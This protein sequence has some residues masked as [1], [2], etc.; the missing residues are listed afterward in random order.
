VLL[1]RTV[2]RVEL[3]L[4]VGCGC[5]A[6]PK[7]GI[8]LA[9]CPRRHMD[10]S[11]PQVF[12]VLSSVLALACG[13]PPT[14]HSPCGEG[15]DESPVTG[16]LAIRYSGWAGDLDPIPFPVHVHDAASVGATFQGCGYAGDDWWW[17]TT[18]FQFEE[19]SAFPQTYD[20]TAVGLPRADAFIER[21]TD[22][23]P[24]NCRREWFYPQ[25][26]SLALTGT[27]HEY[28]LGNQRV[29]TS[30]LVQL[31]PRSTSGDSLSVVADLTWADPS[32]SP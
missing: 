32:A 6:A 3:N 17:I 11:R 20:M 19:G 4:R 12:V 18:S 27:L 13:G 28:D 8:R 16:T 2:R 15:I 1:R 9:W 24:S 23:D 7:R 30:Y 21:C 26:Q 10:R 29:K 14:R 25:L 22:G 31:D 5:L